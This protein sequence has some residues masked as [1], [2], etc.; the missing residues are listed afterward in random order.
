MTTP[1]RLER[2]RFAEELRDCGPDAPTL[3]G[4]WTTRDL[5]AHVILRDRRPDAAPGV[6]VSSL[7]GYTTRVQNKIAA[8][9]WDDIVERVR[10]GPPRW[11][12]ARIDRIER[13]LNTIEFFVHVEDVRRA[14]PD[15]KPRELGDDLGDDLTAALRRASKLLAR[16]APAGIILEPDHG[17]ARIVANDAEPPVIVRG[18]I[19]ELVLWMFGRQEHAR[20]EYEGDADAVTALRSANFGI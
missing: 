10:V 3:C 8:R 2:F 15:W 12:P 17:R 11:S 6:L 14:Q 19:G 20:V 7:S 1:A 16:T 4:G 5:A 9:P 13:L 18:A